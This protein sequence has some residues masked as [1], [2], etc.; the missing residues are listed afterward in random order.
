MPGVSP[1]HPELLAL[2]E[3]GVTEEMFAEAAKT[4]VKKQKDFAYMLGILKRQLESA[5]NI[6]NLP[7][8]VPHGTQ[9]IDSR[10]AVEAEGVEKGFGKW[11]ENKEHWHVYKARVRG[12]T[13]PAVDPSIA[14][15]VTGALKS[16]APA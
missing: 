12:K 4:A 3:R 9:D 5:A 7:A 14:A 10:A 15:M 2:I 8:A 11:D 16:G 13:Q 6:G 1:Q